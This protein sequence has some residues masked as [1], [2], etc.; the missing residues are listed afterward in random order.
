M[1]IYYGQQWRNSFLDYHR[2]P[3]EMRIRVRA[4]CP[5]EALQDVFPVQPR[6]VRRLWNYYREVGL[7]ELSRKI[8]SRL[9]ERLRNQCFMCI[10]VGEVLEADDASGHAPGAEVAFVAPA[11]P[12]C[13]ERI[14]LPA[15]LVTPIPA[16]LLQKL[17]RPESVCLYRG[18][19]GADFVNWDAVAGWSRFSGADVGKVAARL[20][21]WV[22]ETLHKLDSDTARV[23]PL[24]RSTPVAER[25]GDP[26]PKRGERTAVLFGLGN[27]AKTCILPNIDRRI[28]VQCIHEVEPRQIGPYR[29]GGPTYDSSETF[30]PDERYDVCFIAGYHHTHADLAAEALRRGSWVVVEKPLATTRGELDRLLGALREHPGRL[31]AGFH[32]RYNPLWS[33][34]RRDLQLK[35]GEPVNYHCI[36]FETPLRRKHWYNWPNSRSRIVSNGCHWLDHFLFM[37][38][39]A[40]PQR[41]DLWAARNGDLHVS[42]E[43]ANG[44]AMSMSLTDQGSRRI[45]L[46]DHVQLRANGI[47]VRVDNAGRYLAEDHRRIV[48]RKRINK[49]LMWRRMYQSISA[50]ILAGRP[51]DSIESVQRGTELMLALDEMHASTAGP[52]AN[53]PAPGDPHELDERGGPVRPFTAPRSIRGPDRGRGLQPFSGMGTAV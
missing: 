17:S 34:A 8:K 7:I 35:G 24:A 20:V 53:V 43:L 9:R 29:A 36:V 25:K 45:G 28:H 15:S 41:H 49:M 14:C 40:V 23:L 3:G 31:F 6:S 51:G 44:A 2:G 37:N 48:R 52:I 33:L 19:A 26:P 46:Q 10:G 50:S 11:H 21:P 1:F 5:L 32:M 42:V 18:A 22:L 39:Y 4:W 13:V 27:Y 47:T 38:G 16:G 30:R 12:E